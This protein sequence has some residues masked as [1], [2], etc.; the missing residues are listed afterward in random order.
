MLITDD[1]RDQVKTLHATSGWGK[2]GH[3]FAAYVAELYKRDGHTSVLDYGCGKGRLADELEHY[4]ISC[5]NYD[6]AL[7]KFNFPPEPHDFV[8][9]FDVL[10]HIEPDLL[11]NVLKDLH[12]VTR[13]FG[14]FT[15]A[16]RPAD[17]KLPDGRNAHLII[18]PR[19]W[20]LAKLDPYFRL[21]APPAGDHRQFIVFVRPR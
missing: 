7:E 19:G 17:K 3:Q 1:Y 21:V 4:G 9:C 20:W 13:K 15:V 14:M 18:E 11:E 5:T 2:I 16:T 8:V 12:R 10:E 6:P